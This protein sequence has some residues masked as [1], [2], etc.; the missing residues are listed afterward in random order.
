MNT[1][2]G[3]VWVLNLLVFSCTVRTPSYATKSLY[4]PLKDQKYPRPPRSKKIVGKRPP[5]IG[6]FSMNN[7]IKTPNFSK[8]VRERA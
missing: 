5:K 2:M 4:P 8:S 6:Y 1:T 3:V 7:T